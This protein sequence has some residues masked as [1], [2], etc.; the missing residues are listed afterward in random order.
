MSSDFQTKKIMRL[1][2]AL[3][4]D[5]NG[6][7]ERSDLVKEAANLAELRGLDPKSKEASTLSQMLEAMYKDLFTM[8]GP[9]GNA[10]CEQLVGFW[11]K[12]ASGVRA[13][14]MGALE[15]LKM[16]GRATMALLDADKSN[17]I[18]YTEYD[19][20]VRS[21]NPAVKFDTKAAWQKL[22]ADK[23]GCLTVTEMD[24]V[25]REFFVD[26]DPNAAGSY[27]LGPIS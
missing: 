18:T 13:N 5:N 24:K 8:A 7:L 17:T 4:Y 22:D 20:W 26:G 6:F 19:A 10:T 9:K 11:Q 15:G 2:Q 3:D 25:L 14:D 23:D 27:L 21:L 12:I 16:A 1:F